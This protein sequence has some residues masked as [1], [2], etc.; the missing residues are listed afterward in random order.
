[1]ARIRLDEDTSDESTRLEARIGFRREFR[2][3]FA[4]TTKK[5]KKPKACFF[6]F[7]LLYESSARGILFV[8]Y[9]SDLLLSR[10][11]AYSPHEA[12]FS[13]PERIAHPVLSRV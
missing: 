7:E 6:F 11:L 9:E 5:G 2:A 1:L 13:L 10:F 12:S 4:K 8:A 3:K